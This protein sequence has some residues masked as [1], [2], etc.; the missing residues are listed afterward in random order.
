MK[1]ISLSLLLIFSVSFIVAQPNYSLK[2]Y[3]VQ[4]GKKTRFYAREAKGLMK[5]GEYNNAVL[6]AAMA[7]K[8]AEKKSHFSNAQ[9]RLN[10]T[11]QPSLE[12]SL[13]RI[14]RLNQSTATFAGDQ[15]VTNVAELIR[16]YTTIGDIQQI[17]AS[18]PRKS[19]NPAKKRDAG[20]SYEPVDYSKELE[21]TRTKFE[22]SKKEAA[23][24]HYA[25]GRELENSEEKVE[26]KQAAKHFRWANQYVPDY[27]DAMERY[28]GIKIVATTRMGVNK[29]DMSVST[30]Y[31]DVAARLTDELLSSLSTKAKTLE[32][33]EVIDR[34]QLD[35]VI[36]E[37]K[38]SLSGL[39]DESTTAEIGE[40]KGV[41]VILVGNVTENIVDRQESGPS[42]KSY[43]K[44][45]VLRKEKYTDEDGK[46]KTREIK[47]DVKAT[48][49]IFTKS[50]EATVGCTFKVIDVQTGQVLESGSTTGTDTWTFRW[51]GSFTGDK[52]ALP[53]IPREERKYPG[54]SKM[55]N[56]ASKEA[57]AK[58]FKSLTSYISTVGN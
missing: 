30:R 24:M 35:K 18:I 1:G 16:I 15:T 27:R 36:K 54:F 32:F 45:V 42:E 47:G 51:I 21:A 25:K 10:E 56:S 38:L 9:E 58:V 52:R 34:D 46:E 2:T 5:R 7:L 43:T 29:F 31:G 26:L 44:N 4:K 49:K 3:K 28:N 12:G 17:L 33:F 39:M 55:T 23:V 14:E 48:A 22:E 50:A 37:Q 13:T 41:D 20:F 57:S 40:L 8:T 53:V 6:N 19:F 11:Y